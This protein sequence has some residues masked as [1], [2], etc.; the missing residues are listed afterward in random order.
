MDDSSLNQ[1]LEQQT[2]T[3]KCT[4]HNVN[5]NSY[6]AGPLTKF[7][8]RF[9]VSN[10]MESF[11]STEIGFKLAHSVLKALG[12]VTKYNNTNEEKES[13]P[14]FTMNLKAQF[15]MPNGHYY[16]QCKT[17]HFDTNKCIQLVTDVGGDV[18]KIIPNMLQRYTS[19]YVNKET[20]QIE[21]IM[22]LGTTPIANNNLSSLVGVPASYCNNMIGRYQE[23]L[24]KDFIEFFSE[25]WAMCLFCDQ[26]DAVRIQITFANPI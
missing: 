13:I 12:I 23:G 1:V 9:G 19:V 7:S 16:F 18:D 21:S 20:G 5:H 24:V 10:S 8:R 22:Y 26:F 17:A 3:C 11:N 6:A 4:I 25:N 14:V 2:N 15:R